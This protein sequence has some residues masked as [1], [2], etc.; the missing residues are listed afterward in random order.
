MGRSPGQI[1]GRMASAD[2]E[3]RLGPETIH[4]FVYSPAGRGAGPPRQLARRKARRGRR[5]RRG[6]REPSIPNRAPIHQRPATAHLRS[7][8][9]HWE[10]DLMRFRRQRDILLTLQQRR[11]RLA[12][13][14]RLQ[15]KDAQGA[16][17]IVE[18]LAGLPVRARRTILHDDGGAFARH[19]TVADAIGLRA[20]FRDPRS[21]LSAD[22]HSKSPAGR[23]LAARLHRER[24]WPPASRSAPQDRP[25]GMQ[26]RRHRR[27][28][29]DPRLNPARMPRPSNPDRGVRRRP[30]RRA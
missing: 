3:R 26:R 12:L 1:A 28:R 29:P 6:R 10:G 7:R 19:E 20:F 25:S 9:G 11:S 8:F 5:R 18:E 27:R 15:S 21:P 23:C 22:P 30:R 14:R 24:R 2:S 4:R 16:A 13:A 17:A